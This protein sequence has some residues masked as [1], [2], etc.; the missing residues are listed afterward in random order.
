MVLDLSSTLLL[1]FGLLAVVIGM[2]AG[3]FPAVF[4]SQIKVLQVLKGLPAFRAF[5]R[6]TLRK[7]LIVMQY[8]FSLMFI[9][10]TIIGY[11]QYQSFLAFDLGFDTENVLNIDLQGNK[12]ELLTQKLSAL[13]AVSDNFAINP[14]DRSWQ[15]LEC[16]I[17]I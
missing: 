13:P 7:S 12:A 4:F 10:A 2:M 5:R 17:K 14:G 9:T 6:L 8:T 1:S 16:L 15:Y 11:H 3:M